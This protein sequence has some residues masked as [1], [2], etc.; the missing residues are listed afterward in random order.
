MQIAIKVIKG[1]QTMF[2]NFSTLSLGRKCLNENER[3][4]EMYCDNINNHECWSNCKN[5]EL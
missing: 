3:K 5:W 1:S 4:H 2:C